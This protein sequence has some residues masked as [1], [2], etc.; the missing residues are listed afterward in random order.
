MAKNFILAVCLATGYD[1]CLGDEILIIDLLFYSTWASSQRSVIQG[2]MS[3][4][5]GLK[6]IQ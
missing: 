5:K 4:L 1:T 6:T 2:E 3:N